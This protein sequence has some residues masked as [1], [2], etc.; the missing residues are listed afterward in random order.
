MTPEQEPEGA[1][2]VSY[3][4]AW[5]KCAPEQSATARE[6]C[7]S[8]GN[9]NGVSAPAGVWARGTVGNEVSHVTGAKIV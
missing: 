5:R 8:S 4:A 6:C 1:E 3:T 2:G 7:M 9:R